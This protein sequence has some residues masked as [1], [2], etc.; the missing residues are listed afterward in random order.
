MGYAYPS[1]E[2]FGEVS[3]IVTPMG[4]Q[5]TISYAQ[6]GTDYGLPLAV[7]GAATTQ[8]D[9]QTVLQENES[10]GY[11]AQGNLVSYGTGNGTWQLAY[12]GLNRLTASTDP[13][14]HTSYTYYFPNRAVS[15]T[16][17]PSQHAA[18][19]AGTYATDAGILH[20]YD[21]DGNE[22]TQ[23]HHHGNVD[24]KT[25]NFYDGADRLVE[26]A[27]PGDTD[28][29]PVYTRY[30]YDLSAGGSVAVGG[31]SVRAYGNL[32]RTQEYTPTTISV[33]TNPTQSTTTTFVDVR[34]QAFDALDRLVGKI[35]FP[36][37]TNTTAVQATSAYDTSSATLGLLAST[38]DA[39]GETAAMSY[40]A[41]GRE[42]G[43]TFSGDNGTTPGRTYVYDPNGR[44]AIVTSLVYGAQSS[45]Y[46]P[47]GRLK[48]VTEP[49]GGGV[50]SPATIGYDYYPD[51]HRKDLTV[52]S[53]ALNAPASAPLM[54]YVYRADGKRTALTFTYGGVSYPYTWTYSN[55]GRRTAQ[56]DPF[57]GT[58]VPHDPSVAPPSPTYAAKQW[59]YDAN[60]DLQT[61]SLPVI[62]HY[63]Q[64]THDLEGAV[65]AYTVMPI[66]PPSPGATYQ[67]TI[68][69]NIV[70]ETSAV[71]YMNPP[72][73]GTGNH[74]TISR[75]NY[76]NGHTIPYV[77]LAGYPNNGKAVYDLVNGV[78]TQLDEYSI[79]SDTNYECGYPSVTNEVY[80][81][82][83]RHTATNAYLYDMY[84]SGG[85]YNDTTTYDAENHPVQAVQN[86]A[87]PSD[88]EIGTWTMPWGPNGHPIALT[89]S[90]TGGT[91]STTYLHYDGD[92]LLFTTSATGQLYEVRPELL[93][94][95]LTGT[96]LPFTTPVPGGFVVQD[97][98]FSELNVTSHDAASYS[99]LDYGSGPL[100]TGKVTTTTDLSDAG[101][102]SAASAVDATEQLS[103][104]PNLQ[105]THPDGFT[106]P[107]GV[108][109]GV[110][111]MD[112]DLGTWKSP[113][114]YAGDV[115]D[116]MSQKPYMWN[117]N[118][119]YQYSDPSGYQ[120]EE[121]EWALKLA[122]LAL[123]Q[124]SLSGE[125]K[126]TYTWKR[127]GFANDSRAREHFEK[128]VIEKK[129]FGFATELDYVKA[130]TDFR[131]STI[132]GKQAKLNSDGTLRLY[133]PKTNTFASYNA[134]GTTRTMF[135]PDDGQ[136]Y[137]D[138]Q[139]GQTV[140]A[141]GTVIAH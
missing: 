85:Q 53:S 109:Q 124:S 123:R 19:A 76:Q 90:P 9:G 112:P 137:F 13:D 116:P 12:D 140:I 21:P 135:K 60:G 23:I 113:D 120:S 107:L 1:W 25:Q 57:T 104:S 71:T 33:I 125:Q 69:T 34:G 41:L 22:L 103:L 47:D 20:T 131:D 2:P 130:A 88:V 98:D 39:I 97:R 75:F 82:A 139:R 45:V 134:D 64:M 93:G 58:P 136:K 16:E 72:N 30:L 108:I 7:I 84:C 117:G 59:T 56:S 100:K 141:P 10:F 91:P 63:T 122:G 18:N 133:D 74:V 89:N 40:D 118:N 8:V 78:R 66:A 31:L 80:D 127:S 14:G 79:S 43:V 44:P 110:R 128:H 3:A 61:L 28:S 37:N 70:G 32:Y 5:R 68:G 65:S 35:T 11:D 27:L 46:D 54:T 138:Q 114:A 38:T 87:V 106:T 77:K 83:G 92:T 95:Y 132:P 62:G 99:A 52:Q 67:M 4:Y 96:E 49:S 121:I 6:S 17:T 115:R 81:N 94:S 48:S 86:N 129:E 36:P 51:G 101:A 26:V 50:T 29:S 42:T 111:A 15:K 102:P 126:V 73:A 105:Y 55:A 119:P 24:G